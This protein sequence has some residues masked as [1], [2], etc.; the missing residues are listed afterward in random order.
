VTPEPPKRPEE[1]PGETE[2]LQAR[3]PDPRTES[4]PEDVGAEKTGR[5]AGGVHHDKTPRTLAKQ[6]HKHR[7]LEMGRPR[8][9]GRAGA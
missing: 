1:K 9:T 5:A 6:E 3:G 7:P 2:P 4:R 8:D